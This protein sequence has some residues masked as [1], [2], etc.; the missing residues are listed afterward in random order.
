M[1]GG[2]AQKHTGPFKVREPAGRGADC[3]EI[4]ATDYWETRYL[5]RLRSSAFEPAGHGFASKRGENKI[6]MG[7]EG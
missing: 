7:G 4:I 6:R 1:A 5:Q 3:P 2:A